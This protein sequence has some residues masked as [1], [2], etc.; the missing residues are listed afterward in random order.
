MAVG[1][2]GGGETKLLRSNSALK[3]FINNEGDLAKG[4]GWAWERRAGWKKGENCG[5]SFRSNI[6]SREHCKS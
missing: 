4:E 2:A 5:A 1:R 6:F 3:C